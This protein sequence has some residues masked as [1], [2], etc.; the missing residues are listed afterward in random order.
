MDI[1]DPG[2]RQYE[3]WPITISQ[4]DNYLMEEGYELPI[5]HISEA[6]QVVNVVNSQNGELVSSLRVKG[7]TYQAKVPNP[8]TYNILIGE[9]GDQQQIENLI[10]KEKNREK[11][12]VTIR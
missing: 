6:D 8:G 4:T 9:S 7:Q 1:T 10:A 2:S 12:K 11:L 5:L 3:G